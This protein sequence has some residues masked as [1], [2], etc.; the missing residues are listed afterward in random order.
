M[1]IRTQRLGSL[2]LARGTREGF[3]SGDGVMMDKLGSEPV[4]VLRSPPHEVLLA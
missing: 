1:E 3:G 2:C 4:P